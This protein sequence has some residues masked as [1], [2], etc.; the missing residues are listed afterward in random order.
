MRQIG[1]CF[2]VALAVLLAGCANHIAA[3]KTLLATG[4]TVNAAM[5]VYGELYRAGA[6]EADEIASV[7]EKHATFQLAYNKAVQLVGGDL[8]QMTPA[9]VGALASDLIIFIHQ[10]KARKGS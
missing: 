9:E 2:T 7:R 3:V 10:L 8:K 4:E 5:N 6:L 1:L